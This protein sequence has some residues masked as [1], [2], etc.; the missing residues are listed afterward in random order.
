MNGMVSAQIIVGAYLLPVVV[1]WKEGSVGAN[2][3]SN[4]TCHCLGIPQTKGE[5]H[6]KD[7]LH[8]QWAHLQ[9]IRQC[10][11]HVHDATPIGSQR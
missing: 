5:V 7:I 4:R 2:V 10:H 1:P 11:C 6:A 3:Q 9:E 8:L